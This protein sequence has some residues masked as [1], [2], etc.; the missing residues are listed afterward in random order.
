MVIAPQNSSKIIINDLGGNNLSYFRYPLGESIE[1]IKSSVM[2]T[3]DIPIIT[4][5]WQRLTSQYERNLIYMTSSIPVFVKQGDVIH[6]ESNDSE[7]G[8]MILELI[9]SEWTIVRPFS[10]DDYVSNS[11][12]EIRINIRNSASTE[13][14]SKNI[15]NIRL[16]HTHNSDSKYVGAPN[17]KIYFSV[18]TNSHAYVNNEND[19]TDSNCD[20]EL[21]IIQ[22]AVLSLP[23]NYDYSEE[24]KSV[25]VI[26]LCHGFTGNVSFEKWYSNDAD[27]L[28]LIDFFNKNGFAVFDVADTENSVNGQICDVGC[29]QLLESYYKSFEYVKR[30]YNVQDKCMIYGM[31]HGTY[32]ALNMVKKHGNVIKGVCICGPVVSYK[33]YFDFQEGAFSEVIAKKFGF[34]DQ[35]GETYETDKMIPYDFYYNILNIQDKDYLFGNFPPIKI[36]I[37]G[38]D[39]LEVNENSKKVFNAIKNSGNTVYVR[40]VNGYDHHNITMCNS[41]G[42][43][44]E[45]IMFFQRYN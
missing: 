15:K 35:S 12:K 20:S 18:S 24:S 6:L 17:D 38:S 16:L 33:Y 7:M 28:S 34:V 36:L 10:S 43:K 45:V 11:E 44:E 8:F 30:N 39:N 26:M 27:F 4:G 40:S 32:T 13:L 41:D 21:Y 31:S 42:L 19:S 22:N 1:Y 3:N 2:H 23:I 14:T 5:M 9:E 25:P 37:G 29:P